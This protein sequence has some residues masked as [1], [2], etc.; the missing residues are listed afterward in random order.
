MA[1][2]NTLRNKMGK[3]VVVLVSAAILS[4]ILNDLLGSNSIFFRDNSTGSINGNDITI[5]EYQSVVDFQ[6]R[7]FTVFANR[8]PT[9]TD[10]YTINDRAWLWLLGE[11]AFQEEYDKLGIE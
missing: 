4:F 5:N 6:E 11:Y 7:N 9:E 10:K 8:Q 1:L 2:I 3:F